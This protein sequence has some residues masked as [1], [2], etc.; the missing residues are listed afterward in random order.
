M[1]LNKN[2]IVVLFVLM[3]N[4]SYSQTT[5]SGVVKDGELNVVSNCNVVLKDPTNKL[6]ITFTHSQGKGTFKFNTNKFG[7]FFLVFSAFN[8]APKTFEIEV[9]SESKVIEKN[10][11]LTSKS[12][13]LSE[14]IV[15]QERAI[16][17]KK[18][19]ITFL[20]K[21]F[22]Q[23]NEQV[24]EDLLKKIPG[25]TIDQNGTI[26]VGSQEIEKVMVDGDDFFEKGYKLLT[27]NMPVN[28]IEK[29]ELYQHYSNN[30]H[31]KGIENSN[32]V[33]LNLTLKENF[34]RQWFGNMLLGY[35]LVSENR[36]EIGSNLM[37][38]GK[39]NKFYFITNLNNIGNN[40]TGEINNIIR[41]YRMDG[42]EIIGDNQSANALLDLSTFNPTLKQKRVNF[43]N[44]EMVSLNSIF[45]LSSK[46]KL[47]AIGFFNSDENDFFRN[48]FQTFSVGNTSF[49]NSEKFVGRKTQ[50]TGFGKIDLI[51]DISKTKTFEYT[52]KLSTTNDK[53]RSDLVFN[54]DF[55]NENLKNDNQ[56]MDQKLVWTNKFKS[57]KVLLISGRYINEKTPQN[58]DV[59]KFI[60]QDLFTQTA[61]NILQTSENEMQFAG[62][63]AY[64]LDRKANGNL[65][66]LRFGNQF[67]EDDLYSHFKIK[68]NE[69]D[70]SEP[71]GFQNKV[72][73][74]T[75]D[76]YINTIYRF[77][78][79][80]ITMASQLDIH[81]LFN[82]IKTVENLQIQNPFFINPKLGFEW[83]INKK[84]RVL[85]S[86]S[87]NNTN[88]TILDVYNGYIQTSF[89][90]FSKGTGSFNQLNTSTALVNYAFGNWGE[91]FFGNFSVLFL[92]DNDFFSTNTLLTQN[93]SQYEKVLFK[94]RELLTFFTNIE[95]YFKPISSNLKITIEGSKTNYKNS[96]N[97]S[98]LREIKNNSLN[99]GFE[100]RSGFKGLLNYHI[101][102]KWNY[103]EIK[104]TNINSY[105]DSMAF[106]D[107]S[108]VIN[109]KLNFQIQTERYYFGNLDKD[110][111]KYY[112]MDLEARYSQPS[113]KIQFSLSGNNLFNTATFRSYSLSDISISKTEYRLQPRYVL[114]KMEFR[115]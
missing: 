113:G 110:S 103:N 72:S 29:V 77:K 46:V 73:Y 17:I 60:Y 66:E 4:I 5:I 96:V 15:I 19:T 62:I 1:I 32:K 85:T 43:N 37:N 44:A 57:N 9:T 59:N 27:K 2:R 23:G 101:G 105:T 25:L 50:I 78:Y 20:A 10:A 86:Y 87:I 22:L 38:F 93:Y 107:L 109:D 108:F 84:N 42:I 53:N 28:P 8:Y 7:K 47:K 97:Y 64:L 49:E 26:K 6:I 114:L 99:Y 76:L 12:L 98:D 33:A 56:L 63:E 24:V 69:I 41:P 115:F 95:R 106:L 65:F 45:T 34:K 82:S 71:S 61:N 100:I 80:K 58:Y 89:R 39:K 75:S 67:R 55:I 18:D 31:L 35:G 112:F 11:V 88:A 48:S 68:N 13:E 40:A 111:N 79:K 90:S 92:K 21:S 54:G 14:V 102:S 94:N 52:G 70:V 36:Y 16:T 51:Y 3:L 91:K 104:T 30:K 81:Q 74:S 83:E